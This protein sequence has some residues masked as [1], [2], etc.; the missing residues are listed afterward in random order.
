MVIAKPGF[1]MLILAETNSQKNNEMGFIEYAIFKMQKNGAMKLL[2]D[3]RETNL[4][5]DQWL[6]KA[7]HLETNLQWFYDAENDCLKMLSVDEK[8]TNI[9]LNVIGLNNQ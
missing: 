4:P 7:H 2:G 3:I 1:L 8:T 6:V 5:K 9:L